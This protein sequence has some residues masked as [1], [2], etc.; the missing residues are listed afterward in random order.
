MMS[1]LPIRLSSAPAAVG[2]TRLSS[3]G[4]MQPNITAY[5]IAFVVSAALVVESRHVISQWRGAACGGG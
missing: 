1:E 2:A 5:H 3:G 4:T